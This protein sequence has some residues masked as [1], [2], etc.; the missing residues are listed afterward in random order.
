MLPNDATEKLLDDQ[1]RRKLFLFF[2]L[3]A[4]LFKP[5][6]WKQDGQNRMLVLQQTNDAKSA[7]IQDFRGGVRPLAEPELPSG[8]GSSGA[9]V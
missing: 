9:F 6:G 4:W 3:K 2:C 7:A 8:R 1:L 5:S